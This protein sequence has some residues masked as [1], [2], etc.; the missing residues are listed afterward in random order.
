MPQSLSLSLSLPLSLSLSLSLPLSL[1]VPEPEPVTVVD[2]VAG[3]LMVRM[4]GDG[5]FLTWVVAS[6]VT[7]TGTG[8]DGAVKPQVSALNSAATLDSVESRYRQSAYDA[9]L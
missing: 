3:N 2:I 1:P 8:S 5:V 9:C 4:G 6:S 7:V